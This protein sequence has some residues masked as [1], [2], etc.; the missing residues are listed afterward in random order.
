MGLPGRVG[1]GR[2]PRP[3]CAPSSSSWPGRTRGGGY[4]RVHGEIARLGTGWGRTIRRI[5]AAVGAP[6]PRRASSAR[7]Q[8]LATQASALLACDFLHVDTVLLR[9]VYVLFVMEGSDPGS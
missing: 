4:R 2:R 8:F 5:L 6:A 9:R 3:R 1:D 7:R